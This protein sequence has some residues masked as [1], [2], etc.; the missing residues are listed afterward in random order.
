MVI[1]WLQ[2]TSRSCE[3]LELALDDETCSPGTCES[4]EG[5]D[6]EHQDEFSFLGSI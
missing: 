4:C 3:G 2:A 1:T 6:C 5:E